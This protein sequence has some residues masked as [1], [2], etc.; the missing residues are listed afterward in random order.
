[1]KGINGWLEIGEPNHLHCHHV[2]L[3]SHSNLLCCALLIFQ[4][5]LSPALSGAQVQGIFSGVSPW[6][7]EKKK[8]H[9]KEKVEEA[10]QLLIELNVT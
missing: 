7:I 2:W 3:I 9:D 8:K 1:M 5:G 6:E 4:R 10:D